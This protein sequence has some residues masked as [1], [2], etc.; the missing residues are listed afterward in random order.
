MTFLSRHCAGVSFRKGHRS[1]SLRLGDGGMAKPTRLGSLGE[2]A[3]PETLFDDL[4]PDDQFAVRQLNLLQLSSLFEEN[5]VAPLRPRP[6]PAKSTEISLRNAS[7][8]LQVMTNDILFIDYHCTAVHRRSLRRI[9]P[10]RRG[11]KR[12]IPE[13][14]KCLE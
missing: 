11:R 1:P 2:S 3:D 8:F 14:V 9:R 6:Q 7:I 12:S 13:R 5:K 4:S 10:L